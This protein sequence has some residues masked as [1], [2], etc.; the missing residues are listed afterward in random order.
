MHVSFN[1]ISLVTSSI[2]PPSSGLLVAKLR[3][4]F[5]ELGRQLDLPQT[6]HDVFMDTR[7][8]NHSNAI[9][10]GIE[11]HSIVCNV[12]AF[13]YEINIMLMGLRYEAIRSLVH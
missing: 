11:G 6:I 13:L 1:S 8:F 7:F 3:V 9:E 4:C 12:N 10:K 5:W 2:L